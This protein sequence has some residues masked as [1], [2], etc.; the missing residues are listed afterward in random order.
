VCTVSA[1]P[2][3]NWR[4]LPALTTYNIDKFLNLAYSFG[5]D[6]THLERYERAKLIT[7]PKKKKGRGRRCE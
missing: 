5:T 3:N 1:N 7:L 2:D 4:D 6:F